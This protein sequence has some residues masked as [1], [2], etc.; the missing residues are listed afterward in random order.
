M[1]LHEIALIG[2]VSLSLTI[3]FLRGAVR[4]E[5]EHRN[6]RKDRL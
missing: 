3:W 5:I 2:V 4:A 6:C 1:T